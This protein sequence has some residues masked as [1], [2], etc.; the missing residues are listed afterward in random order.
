M[1]RTLGEWV[2]G[3][4]CTG[5]ADADGITEGDLVAAHVEEARRNACNRLRIDGPL[6]RAAQHAR[7]VPAHRQLFEHEPILKEEVVVVEEESEEVLCC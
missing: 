5:S 1:P 7:H 2:I 3:G 4:I 6:V